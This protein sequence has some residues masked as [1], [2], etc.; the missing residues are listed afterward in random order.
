[1]LQSVKKKSDEYQVEKNIVGRGSYGQIFLGTNKYTGE[2][3]IVKKIDNIFRGEHIA[4]RI[5]REIKILRLL[6]HHPNIISLKHIIAPKEPKNTYN[7][8]SLVFEKM[9]T[10]LGK[11]LDTKQILTEPHSQ[12]FLFQLL[13]G[14]HY[15]HSAGIAH[16]DL[17]P[18]N[19]LINSNCDLKI[20]DFN[21]S[22]P[23]H[24]P[25]EIAPSME[26]GPIPLTRN[27][28]GHVVTRYY[29][30]PELMMRTSQS[31]YDYSVD[32]WS[33]GCI[34]AEILMMQTKNENRKPLFPGTSS[35]PYS[36]EEKTL[37]TC[38]KDQLNVI[39]DLLGTPTEEDLV[40]IEP[41]E[42][43]LLYL[44]SLPLKAPQSLQKN[45]LTSKMCRPSISCNVVWS[46][47][48]KNE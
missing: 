2:A 34:F 6:G 27:L 9:E 29:R 24:I 7:T 22:R 39:F 1:M 4:K 43:K 46:S 3:V 32:M 15:L 37:S 44:K 40:S 25:P 14:V 19:I 48:L 36:N 21:L 38:P 12:Y 17:K 13:C 47:I 35:I 23:L 11:I 16:R 26:D 30:A 8:L 18:A 5:L 33:I 28:T 20:C 31:K 41:D 45:V 42:S 10:D